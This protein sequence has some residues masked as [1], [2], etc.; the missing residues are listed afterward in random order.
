MYDPFL[1]DPLKELRVLPLE[2]VT[3]TTFFIATQNFKEYERK[4]KNP[5][6]LIKFT[7]NV[8][9]NML[10]RPDIIGKT[11]GYIYVEETIKLLSHIYKNS[12]KIQVIINF[13]ANYHFYIIRSTMTQK[14]YLD[15]CVDDSLLLQLQS[16]N[17][18]KDY[19]LIFDFYAHIRR[20]TLNHYLKQ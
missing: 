14:E 15:L 11:W 13:I 16:I 8:L 10:N 1:N 7:M 12:E 4:L 18:N 17:K 5:G 20:V 9:Q 6:D 2:Y 3:P 19:E